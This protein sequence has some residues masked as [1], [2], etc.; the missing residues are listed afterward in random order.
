MTKAKFAVVNKRPS[1]VLMT[2]RMRSVTTAYRSSSVPFDHQVR[3]YGPSVNQ[4]T[5]ES[6]DSLEPECLALGNV[7]Y[8]ARISFIGVE[9][10]KRCRV[11][12]YASNTGGKPSDDE[13]SGD[14]AENRAAEG[15]P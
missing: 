9:S 1:N 5:R 7:R 14:D 11:I 2:F 10:A 3:D 4:I 15:I 6:A 12:R 13:N 8:R